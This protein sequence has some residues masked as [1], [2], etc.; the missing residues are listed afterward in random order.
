MMKN[1]GKRETLAFLLTN[2]SISLSRI[3]VNLVQYYFKGKIKEVHFKIMLAS[4]DKSSKLTIR[5]STGILVHLQLKK[6]R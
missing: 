4:I 2:V 1:S 6:Q 3:K 5:F